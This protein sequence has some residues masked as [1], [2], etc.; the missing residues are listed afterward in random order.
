MTQRVYAFCV[1][2]G[3]SKGEIMEYRNLGHTG[4]KVSELCMGS[5]QFGWT[6]DENTSYEILDATY[7]AGVNFID[8]ANVYSKWIEGN[9]GGVAESIIGKWIKKSAIPREKL[10]LATKVSGQMSDGPNEEGLS[11]VHIMKAVEDSLRRLD[12]DYIDLYQTHWFD[13]DTPIEETLSTFDDLIRQGKVRYIGCSNYPAW[14]L[15]EALW[16]SEHYQYHRFVSIQPHYSL[17]HRD[18]FE[19]ELADVCRT[20]WI[21]VIPYSPLAAGFLTGKYRKDHTV[22]SQRLRRVREYFNDRNWAL[23]ESMETMGRNKG[24]YT[25]SQIA[26]AW[27]LTDPIITSPIIGPR[28]LEQLNDNLGAAGLRLTHKEKELLDQKSAWN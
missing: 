12:T 8:T 14:R 25:I 3:N 10:V 27:L 15:T 16:T 19:R 24:N 9:P 21:G 2:Y 28:S 18:E 22:D 11:R 6:A 17:V 1:L 20:Y 4:L 26:L 13:K 5:M 23:L 7:N